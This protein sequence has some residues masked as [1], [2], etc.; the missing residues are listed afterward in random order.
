MTATELALS[1]AVE[2][3][4]EWERRAMGY[5]ELAQQAIHHLAEATQALARE[6]VRT[7]HQAE[8]LR[9]MLQVTHDS[10]E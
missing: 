6:R 10:G 9:A 5:R 2:S 7:R 1:H 4:A 3:A 8:Q